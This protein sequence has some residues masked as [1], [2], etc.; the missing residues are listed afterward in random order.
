MLPVEREGVFIVPDLGVLR[1]RV[2]GYLRALKAL[3]LEAY[4]FR[5]L[6]FKALGFCVLERRFR[7]LLNSVA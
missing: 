1:F 7:V 3:T 4:G 2:L 6:C 5:D